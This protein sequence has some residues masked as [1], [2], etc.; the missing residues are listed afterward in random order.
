MIADLTVDK[1]KDTDL[2]SRRC[3]FKSSYGL[4]CRSIELKLAMKQEAQTIMNIHPP[5]HQ[6]WMQ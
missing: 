2:D 5:D 1:D 3:H 4:Y 6:T